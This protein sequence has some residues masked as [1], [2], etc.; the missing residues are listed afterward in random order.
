M[1][2][3]LCTGAR[4]RGLILSRRSFPLA[5]CSS[6]RVLAAMI[7]SR[8]TKPSLQTTHHRHRPHL[9]WPGANA[10][11]VEVQFVEQGAKLVHGALVA[12]SEQ[13]GFA[14]F[15]VSFT[16]YPVE[17]VEHVLLLAA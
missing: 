4:G 13:L 2:R 5:S 9:C 11:P 8:S 6:S 14:H 3:G 10:L 12:S 17:D 16:S 7:S 1:V 15:G